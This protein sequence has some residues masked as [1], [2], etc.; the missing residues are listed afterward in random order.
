M[1]DRS[2]YRAGWQA[3]PFTYNSVLILA[4]SNMER[5]GQLHLRILLRIVRSS[6]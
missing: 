3:E 1:I 5:Q 6:A 4:Q 2:S